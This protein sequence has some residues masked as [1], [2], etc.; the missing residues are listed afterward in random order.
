[1]WFNN[2]IK[3]AVRRKET[4]WKEMLTASTE[5]AKE[6]CMEAFKEEKR[7]VKRYIY[8]SKKKVNE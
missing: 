5:E 8:W 1:M 6:R 7:K 3:A 4:A 2:E